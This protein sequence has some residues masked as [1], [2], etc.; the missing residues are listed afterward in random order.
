[1]APVSNGDISEDDYI[2]EIEELRKKLHEK[3]QENQYLRAQNMAAKRSASETDGLL[4][5][6]KKERN[7]LIALREVFYNSE[8]EEEEPVPEAKLSERRRLTADKNVVI[9]GGHI[10]WQ[11][12]LKELFPNW[13]YVA[14]TAYRI[15]DGAMLE[16]KDKVYF[17]TGY[18][19]HVSNCKF[20]AAV[21]ESTIPF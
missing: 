21:R 10:N 2:K 3:E 8:Q 18:I 5:K 17:Y 16:N 6:N 12:K 4:K 9:I 1:M 14:L 7:G 19:S 11:N 13:K 15:V 20:I